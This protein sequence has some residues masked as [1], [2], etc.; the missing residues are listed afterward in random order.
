LVLSDPTAQILERLERDPTEILAA[1]ELVEAPEDAG[2]TEEPGEPSE[3]SEEEP[4]SADALGGD[5]HGSNANAPAATWP[6]AKARAGRALSIDAF[7]F[8]FA[9]GMLGLSLWAI[10][11]LAHLSPA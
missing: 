10:R 6:A 5:W 1:D 2:C 4:S 7:V 8:V 11:W 9:L 3:L